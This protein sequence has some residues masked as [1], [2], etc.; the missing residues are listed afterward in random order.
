MPLWIY[1]ATDGPISW[2]I[3][4]HERLPM[5]APNCSVKLQYLGSY[6]CPNLAWEEL[7]VLEPELQGPCARVR[8]RRQRLLARARR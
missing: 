2:P 5:P 6:A 7:A 4:A 3:L 1:Y 8:R